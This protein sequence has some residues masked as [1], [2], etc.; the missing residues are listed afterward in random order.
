MHNLLVKTCKADTELIEVPR[1]VC[2]HLIGCS[3]HMESDKL[4]ED[5][6]LWQHLLCPE[7]IFQY[8]YRYSKMKE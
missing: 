2:C 3:K 4:N 8:E 1:F 6:L 5:Y 7:K